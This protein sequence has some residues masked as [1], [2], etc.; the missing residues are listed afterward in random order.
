MRVLKTT[1]SC[2]ELQLILAEKQILTQRRG[3]N[4]SVIM[5]CWTDP[6]THFTPEHLFPL[7]LSKHKLKK[8]QKQSNKIFKKKK[9]RVFLSYTSDWWTEDFRLRLRAELVPDLQISNVFRVTVKLQDDDFNLK[10]S[11]NQVSNQTHIRVFLLRQR[12]RS[13]PS[14][15]GISLFHSSLSTRLLSHKHKVS[16]REVWVEERNQLTAHT[17]RKTRTESEQM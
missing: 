4:E 14:R 9:R 2:L 15:E 13:D 10:I 3:L 8:K 16:W 1:F 17:C 11:K 5:R 7:L 6:Q 12:H